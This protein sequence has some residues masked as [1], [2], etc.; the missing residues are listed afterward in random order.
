MLESN[1]LDAVREDA[2]YGAEEWQFGETQAGL[3]DLDN[4]RAVSH[5]KVTESLKSWRNS[6]ERKTPR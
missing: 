5:E 2:G 1:S 4:G 3:A 6:S